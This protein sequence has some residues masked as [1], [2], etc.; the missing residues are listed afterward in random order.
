MA[1]YTERGEEEEEKRGKKTVLLLLLCVV[2]GE[3]GP[4]ILCV[5]VV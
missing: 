1:L 5:V 2:V 4:H 3:K